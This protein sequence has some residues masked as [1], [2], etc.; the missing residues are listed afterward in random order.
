[1]SLVKQH[2]RQFFEPI[3]MALAA[4]G[5]KQPNMAN[6]KHLW[7]L[8]GPLANYS[9]WLVGRQMHRSKYDLPDMPSRLK[10][11]A[12]F[13]STWLQRSPLEISGTM[14]KFQ[15]KLADR[16]CRMAELS[17]RVQL[18]VVILCTSLYAARHKNDIITEAADTICQELKRRIMGGLPTDR[19]FKQVTSLGRAIS[20]GHF[21]GLDET[22]QAPTMMPYQN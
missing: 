3:G 20:E 7:A 19:Y 10:A 9:K 21:P 5:I 13:A 15:L 17:G 16:Q 22:P 4:N 6:P 2:G 8:K 12:E 14:R 1:K 18:A 11:H